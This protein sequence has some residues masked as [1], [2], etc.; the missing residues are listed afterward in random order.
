MQEKLKI[1]SASGEVVLE[2]DLAGVEKPLMILSGERPGLVETVPQGAEVIGA[3][4]RDEDGWTLASARQDMPVSSGPK[5][6]ADFHLTAGVPCA[7]GP[8]AFRIEREGVATGTVLLWRVGSSAVAADPLVPG[9]NVVAAGLGGASRSGSRFRSPRCS[10]SAHSRGWPS[11]RRTR[12]RPSRAG[13]RSPGRRA[14]RALGSWRRCSSP[15]S[16]RS[17]RSQW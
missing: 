3:L 4:V 14:G 12:R 6:G 7:L 17:P 2:A 8:W 15:D 1:F 11:L 16:P 13:V 10:P 5:T 9:R